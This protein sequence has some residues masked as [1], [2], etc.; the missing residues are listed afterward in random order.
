MNL[1]IK[2]P[3]PN[4]TLKEEDGRQYIFDSFR[5]KYIILTP[6][7]WV[8]QNLLQA[9]VQ[10]YLYP[11]GLIAVEKMLIINQL[12]RRYDAVVYDPLRNP[13][14]LIEC[15]AASVELDEDVLK[16]TLHYYRKL[17]CPYFLISNGNLTFI[18][19]IKEQSFSWLDSVPPYNF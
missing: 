3:K 6:E 7:E 2:Y 10:N 8:R 11:A 5:K 12:K 17:Q 19:A 4:F 16:Q 15:K 14:M 13:W 9:L 18:A 1:N